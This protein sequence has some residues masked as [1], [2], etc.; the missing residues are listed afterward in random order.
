V[1]SIGSQAFSNCSGLLSI[2]VQRSIPPTIGSSTFGIPASACLYV[3]GGSTA[4][5]RAV[6][7]WNRT[8]IIGG[9]VTLTYNGN[10]N[11]GGAAPAQQIHADGA[12][13]IVVG[14][15]SLV[16]SGYAFTGWNTAEDGSGTSHIAGTTFAI[17]ANTTLY[18]QWVAVRTLTY[19][20][21]GSTGGTVPAAQ[22]HNDGATVTAAGRGTLARTGY[23]FNGWNTVANGIGGT[24][25][26]AG[27]TF[28][29]SA[30]TTLYAQWAT[31]V[32]EITGVPN[33]TTPLTPLSLTASIIP[34]GATNKTIVWSVENAGGTG[35]TLYGGTGVTT[36]V[37]TST[38]M[39]VLKAT[40]ANGMDHG[41]A[42]EQMFFVNVQASLTLSQQ[43][44]SLIAV[45][46]EIRDSLTACRSGITNIEAA[47]RNIPQVDPSE[48]NAIV[49]PAPQPANEITA[50]PNPVG[51]S[52]GEINFYRSGKQISSGALTVHD[53]MGNVVRKINIA[54]KTITG[55][56]SGRRIVAQWDLRDANGRTVPEGAYLARGVVRTIDGKREKISLMIGVR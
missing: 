16:K 18:A 41:V 31:P 15:G 27:A 54:D 13:V 12:S 19:D 55:G 22:P 7:G 29:I 49:I 8:C 45:I 6:S 32:A 26:A 1:N 44:D 42:Y 3:P 53:A 2:T 25:Y 33:R 10:G 23:T 37:A 34:A 35:A 46:G 48:N 4:A 47:N 17:G 50:G 40:I 38:G 9:D 24:A 21:N 5:Y 56:A 43:I 36:F 39:A 52:G 14:A 28:T 51:K 30:N 11:T 20:G